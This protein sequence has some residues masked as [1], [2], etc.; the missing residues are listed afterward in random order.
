MKKY[1]M[2]P[3]V[4][5]TVLLSGCSGGRGQI[6]DGDGMVN[7]PPQISQEESDETMKADEAGSGSE[8]YNMEPAAFPGLMVGD[9]FYSIELESNSSA[10]AFFEKIKKESLTI[11]MHDYGSFEKVG[12]LP[13]ELPANDEEIT[14]RPGDIILC[15]GNKLTIYYDENTRNF[16]KIGCIPDV[17]ADELKEVLGDG[18]VTV[19]FSVEWTE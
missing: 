16:T 1:V 11:D 12:D 7:D 17:D 5:L 8:Q 6:M 18:D 10:D 2:I 4:L 14:A 15:Q 9:S 19:E 13:W 3:V